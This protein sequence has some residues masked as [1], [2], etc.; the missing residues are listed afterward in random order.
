[1]SRILVI[2]DAVLFR[3]P[4]AASLRLAGHEVTCAD[5][6]RDALDRLESARPDL[7]VLD[8]AMPVM[9]GPTFLRELRANRDF[10]STPVLVVSA[11]S[12]KTVL[13]QVA[14]MGIQGSLLKSRFTLKELNE[15]V[16]SAL[17]QHS[18]S[19]RSHSSQ[20]GQAMSRV[21]SSS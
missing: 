6:G 8:L 12:D 14:Q 17:G 2:D 15:K 7:V 18:T 5:N 10:G 9:D 1:M 20:C 13:E 19:T 16:K 3:E 4:V 21:A 11:G